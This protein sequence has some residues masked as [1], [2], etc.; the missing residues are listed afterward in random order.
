MNFIN[1][2]NIAGIFFRTKARAYFD[3]LIHLTYIFFLIL[4]QYTPAGYINALYSNNCIMQIYIGRTK[5]NRGNIQIPEYT[6]EFEI[7]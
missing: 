5:S 6:L 1:H 7:T 4:S 2:T 3:Y